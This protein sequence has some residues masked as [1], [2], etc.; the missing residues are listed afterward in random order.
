MR[1]PRAA[2]SLGDVGEEVW[3]VWRGDVNWFEESI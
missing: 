2:R 1:K 3:R